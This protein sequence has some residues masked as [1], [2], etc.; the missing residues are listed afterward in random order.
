MSDSATIQAG[1][2]DAAAASD[3]NATVAQQQAPVATALQDLIAGV[4]GPGGVTKLGNGG[5]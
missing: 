2:A 5:A 4:T 1:E 3:T